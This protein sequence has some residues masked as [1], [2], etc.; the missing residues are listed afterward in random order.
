MADLVIDEWLWSDLAGENTV[1]EQRE[2]FEFLGAIYNKCDRIVSVRGSR[3]D[4]KFFELFRYS[5]VIR[6][7]FAKFFKARFWYNSQKTLM[8]EEEQ[9]QDLPEA[10]ATDTEVKHKDHYLVRAYLT[11]KASQIVTTDNPLKDALTKHG[12]V[13]RHR[14][15]FVPTYISEYGRR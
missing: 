9:L 7:G 2:T 12:I 11:A 1:G 8:L 13:C 14:Q 3:F 10:I 15:E 4:Q 5:D 6:L